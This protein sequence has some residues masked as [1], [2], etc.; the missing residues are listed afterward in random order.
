MNSDEEEDP[1]K[2]IA[3]ESATFYRPATRRQHFAFVRHCHLYPNHDQ[4]DIKRFH[5]KNFDSR[6]DSDT[7]DQLKLHYYHIP[8]PPI[9]SKLLMSSSVYYSSINFT[10]SERCCDFP[11][12]VNGFIPG[13]YDVV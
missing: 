7:T 4:D 10:M 1:I 11:L 6:Y 2:T 12:T 3:R 8:F 5:L 13:S 9:K